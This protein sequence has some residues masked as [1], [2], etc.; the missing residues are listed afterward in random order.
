MKTKRS[1]TMACPLCGLKGAC[2]HTA[3]ELRT[4]ADGQLGLFEGYPLRD[5]VER[6]LAERSR[7][8]RAGK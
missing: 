7:R 4:W 5:T 1:D 8:G 2:R 3:Y 6:F